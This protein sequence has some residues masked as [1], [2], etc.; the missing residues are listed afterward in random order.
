MKNRGFF[1]AIYYYKIIDSQNKSSS[2]SLYRLS[3][4]YEKLGDYEISMRYLNR[5]V[6]EDPYTKKHGFQLLNIILETMI[7]IKQLK[8]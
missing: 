1:K 3:R 5:I 7:M 8:I 6:E 4:C 2:F